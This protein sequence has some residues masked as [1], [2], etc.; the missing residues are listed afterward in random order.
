MSSPNRC[1]LCS[2]E[3]P[4]RNK[5]FIHIKVAHEGSAESINGHSKRTKREAVPENDGLLESEITIIEEDDWFRV[6]CKPQGN[7]QF[8]FLDL[9]ISS[10]IIHLKTKKKA[11][12]HRGQ[13]PQAW[14]QHC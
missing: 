9:L 1:T 2:E 4:S 10:A 5:L 14:V 12:L 13:A 11:W 8:A 7:N 6:I 3:F